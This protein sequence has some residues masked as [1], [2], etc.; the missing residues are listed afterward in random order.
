[1][2][3]FMS[4]LC[5][6]VMICVFACPIAQA[7]GDGQITPRIASCGNCGGSCSQIYV[8]TPYHTYVYIGHCD[9]GTHYEAVYGK[10]W[11]CDYCSNIEYTEGEHYCTGNGGHY[12][13]G[14]CS[15]E[16]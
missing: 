2:K 16:K 5:A 14:S 7:S 12:C 8:Q 1:M 9:H 6:M 13:L 4:F 3:R 11:I 15:C 10:T